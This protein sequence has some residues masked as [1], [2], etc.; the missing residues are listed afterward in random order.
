MV[1]LIESLSVVTGQKDRCGTS[2]LRIGQ[3][4]LPINGAGCIS[5]ASGIYLYSIG[6]SVCLFA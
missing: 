6:D 1:F 4:N 3:P 2:W 5:G